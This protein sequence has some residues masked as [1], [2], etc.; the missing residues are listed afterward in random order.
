MSFTVKFFICVTQPPKKSETIF[1]TFSFRIFP[2]IKQ[3]TSLYQKRYS[4]LIPLIYFI[5][6]VLHKIIPKFKYCFPT[7]WI[8]ILDLSFEEQLLKKDGLT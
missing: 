2:C 7:Y 5:A 4:T 3:S 1:V 8:K 6:I